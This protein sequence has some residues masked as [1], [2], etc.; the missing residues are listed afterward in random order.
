MPIIRDQEYGYRRGLVLG[1]TMAEIAILIIFVLLL[2]LG[3]LLRDQLN[4]LEPKA[5]NYERI[6]SAANSNDPDIIIKQILYTGNLESR[7][8]IAK[9]QL[10]EFREIEKLVEINDAGTNSK[11][12]LPEFVRELV[13]TRDELV[14][15]GITPT[16]NA[17]RRKLD[18]LKA[19]NENLESML[20][21]NANNHSDEIQS[22]TEEIEKLKEKVSGQAREMEAIS[23]LLDETIETKRQLESSVDQSNAELIQENKNLRLANEN[24]K[25]ESFR[26]KSNLMRS[27]TMLDDK[28]REE[29]NTNENLR[30]SLAGLQRQEQSDGRGRDHPPCWSIVVDG[31]SRAEYIFDMALTHRGLIIR[32]R[33]LPHRESDRT[34]LPLAEIEFGSEL[35][36]AKFIK[37]TNPLFRWS[38][39]RECRF[40]VRVFDK[41]GPTDKVQYKY[42]MQSLEQHF[43]KFEELNESF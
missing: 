16:T 39:E 1:L 29:K 3:Y 8:A 42:H 5:Q 43:Y 41:T 27:L 40:Y 11:Q 28:L 36:P 13:L 20:R 4:T 24:L 33:V 10:L 22:Q 12:T 35:P 38:V 25:R 23:E 19:L 2:A 37:V 7:L 26:Q 18:S 32:D 15:Q 21:Q 31:K 9:K 30:E 34:V 6:S 17:V 14:R